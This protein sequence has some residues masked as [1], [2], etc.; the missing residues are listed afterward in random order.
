MQST[1]FTFFCKLGS[2]HYFTCYFIYY[3][4]KVIGIKIADQPQFLNDANVWE[5]QGKGPAYAY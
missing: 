5:V 3:I 4:K 2:R 1:S